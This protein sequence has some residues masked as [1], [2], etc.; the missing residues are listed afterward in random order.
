[1][2]DFMNNCIFDKETPLIGNILDLELQENT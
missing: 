2:Q 1:M